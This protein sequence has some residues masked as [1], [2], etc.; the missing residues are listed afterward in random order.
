MGRVQGGAQC[1]A[2]WLPPKVA[3]LPGSCL[4]A[5]VSKAVP[6]QYAIAAQSAPLLKQ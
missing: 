2:W 4:R 5:C 3:C 6:E 1:E